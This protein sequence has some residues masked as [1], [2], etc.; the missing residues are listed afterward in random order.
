MA[1][2]ERYIFRYV[3]DPHDAQNEFSKLK[4]IGDVK[5]VDSSPSMILGETQPNLIDRIKTAMSN[6]FIIP[7][8]RYEIPDNSV[9][10]RSSPSLVRR[11]K[12]R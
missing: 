11:K 5:V 7:E 10:V 3:G 4:R 9:Q 8:I 2:P 12:K 6:W 1:K